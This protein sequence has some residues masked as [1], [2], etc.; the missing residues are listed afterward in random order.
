MK[1]S[2]LILPLLGLLIASIPHRTKSDTP[3]PVALAT[4]PALYGLYK[5][6]CWIKYSPNGHSVVKGIGSVA[7]GLGAFVAA[8]LLSDA[9]HNPQ[10]IPAA[11]Q[12]K[13]G[14][15]FLLSAAAILGFASCL[16]A[17]STIKD[18][19]QAYNSEN[20]QQP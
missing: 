7:T 11:L 13:N 19:K 6:G 3:L 1:R 10:T 12:E 8:A 15:F 16:L 14:K 17:E 20:G 5:L 2:I 4:G 9:T 18:V